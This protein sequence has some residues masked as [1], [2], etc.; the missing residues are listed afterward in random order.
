MKRVTPVAQQ[1]KRSSRIGKGAGSGA[2]GLSPASK[3]FRRRKG[4][5]DDLEILRVGGQYDDCRRVRSDLSGSG[6][7]D[8]SS[9]AMVRNRL[10][11][12]EHRCAGFARL[13][14]PDSLCRGFDE[15]LVPVL[16]AAGLPR[17]GPPRPRRPDRSDRQLRIAGVGKRWECRCSHDDLTTVLTTTMTTVALPDTSTYTTV[18]LASCLV[19]PLVPTD[20]EFVFIRSAS[21]TPFILRALNPQD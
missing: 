11:E 7:Y 9:P 2:K 3:E 19:T 18:E 14:R 4:Q 5:P 6:E 12:P 16:R 17:C 1:R 20:H 21:A 15:H 13:V 10:D 8:S